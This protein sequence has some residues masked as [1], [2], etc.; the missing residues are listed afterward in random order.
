MGQKA[1]D[2]LVTDGNGE[3]LRYERAAKAKTGMYAEPAR[4]VDLLYTE[5]Q[6]NRGDFGS[7]T[8][9][10]VKAIA[11]ILKRAQPDGAQA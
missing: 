1:N 10:D 8:P 4:L 7:L 2:V 11:A 3:R 6:I 9:D 5:H